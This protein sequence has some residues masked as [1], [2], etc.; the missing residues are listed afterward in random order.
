MS[1]SSKPSSKFALKITRYSS[2]DD[3]KGQVYK[4][5]NVDSS[6]GLATLRK[7]LIGE[8]I[9]DRN[10]RF[11]DAGGGSL[12]F[13]QEEDG[14]LKDIV[15][16]PTDT[17]ACLALLLFVYLADLGSFKDRSHL[18]PIS[19]PT[20]PERPSPKCAATRTPQGM[21]EHC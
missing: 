19:K 16:D 11:Q 6:A 7:Y 17:K 4:L 9:M 10:D 2:V 18:N 13:D 3:S 20:A 14:T 15:K 21:P 12:S 1:E 8:H 5:S